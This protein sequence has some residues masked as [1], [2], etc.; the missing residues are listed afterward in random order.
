MAPKTDSTG[1]IQKPAPKNQ[2]TNATKIV[3]DWFPAVR[4]V[5]PRHMNPDRMGR[6]LFTLMRTNPKIA[7]IADSNPYS[8]VGAIMQCAQ[9]GLEPNTPLGHVYLIPFGKELQTIIGYQGMIELAMRSGKVSNVYAYCVFEDD[10][11]NYELG[12]H[13]DIIHKPFDEGKR[14]VKKITHVYAVARMKDGD[15]IFIVLNRQQVE[16]R[17]AR[18]AAKNSGPWVTD[19][20]EMCKKTAIRMLF[21]SLPK[22]AEMAQATVYDEA[23]ES[24]HRQTNALDPGIIDIMDQNGMIE[25]VASTP[26]AEPK[27]KNKPKEVTDQPE[28]VDK[29]TGEIK[30]E[31]GKTGKQEPMPWE[32]E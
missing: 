27:P 7:A 16:D 17:R 15:P 25:D 28:A 11:F 1:K 9:L 20:E 30:P 6:L 5:L 8:V 32:G 26:V 10:E 14:D 2:D 23:L 22:S 21:K 3:K 31:P 19:Y 29:E 24:G 4:K 12:L 13:P 18:S